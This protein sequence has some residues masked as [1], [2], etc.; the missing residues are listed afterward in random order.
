[1]HHQVGS[2]CTPIIRPRTS[3]IRQTLWARLMA[4]NE[5]NLAIILLKPIVYE[6]DAQQHSRLSA[7]LREANRKGKKMT[8]IRG[9]VR[10]TRGPG[11]LGVHSLERNASTAVALPPH[12]C[13]G[14]GDQERPL[15]QIPD[16]KSQRPKRAA[17]GAHAGSMK[18]ARNDINGPKPL[19]L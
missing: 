8:Q 15:D 16:Q 9:F 7:T 13:A 1:M 10:P 12:A 11:E 4:N 6:H 3:I 2:C 14:I 5:I 18:L 19:S 17:H